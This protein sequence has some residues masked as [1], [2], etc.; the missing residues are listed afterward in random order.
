MSAPLQLPLLFSLNILPEHLSADDSLARRI[1]AQRRVKTM[2]VMR[3]GR[4][5]TTEY[6]EM[7][8]KG[9]QTL[10]AK[11]YFVQHRRQRFDKQ[12]RMVEM[13]M[14]PMAN[15]RMGSQTVFEPAKRL[16]S[17]YVSGGQSTPVL[18]QQT[19]R[20]KHGDTLTIDALFQSL[21]TLG[22]PAQR[23][24]VRSYPSGHDTVIHVSIGY[25]AAGKPTEFTANYSVKRSG[26]VVETGALDYR[27]TPAE[28]PALA[29]DILRWQRHRRGRC[30]PNTR[31]EYDSKG[32]LIQSTYIAD[33]NHVPA[34]PVTTTSADG[35]STMTLHDSSPVL[36][37]FT[38]Y[39]RTPIGR[40]QREERTYELRPDLTD[41]YV[42]QAYKPSFIN[43]EYDAHGLL[44]RKTDSSGFNG[45][46]LIYEVKYTYY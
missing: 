39:Q 3:V 34:P 19:H 29:A 24:L 5:D 15:D 35:Q 11:P 16:Y 43:Y 2:T 9:N 1:F 4:S 38:R 37:Y 46:S 32:W 18:W 17:T 30:V 8:R 12:N 27:S 28:P 40:V 42:R 7:D 10:V 21:P 14:V 33:P 22:A 25:N 36:G 20:S 45:Q 31:N 13:T 44:L 26:R 23:L 6:A 41:D